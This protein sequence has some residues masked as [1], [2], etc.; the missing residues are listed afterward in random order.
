[1][2]LLVEALDLVLKCHLKEAL[3]VAFEGRYPAEPE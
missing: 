1:M 2:S 3:S